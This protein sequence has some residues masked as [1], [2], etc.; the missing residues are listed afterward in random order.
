M[1]EKYLDFIQNALDKI[2]MPIENIEYSKIHWKTNA[3]LTCCD[4]AKNDLMEVHKSLS[5]I[6]NQSTQD[7]NQ[8]KTIVMKVKV[9]LFNIY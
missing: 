7:T 5:L 6:V 8:I 1:Q 2:N 4:N 9:H 3:V